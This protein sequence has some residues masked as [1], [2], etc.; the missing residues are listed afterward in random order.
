MVLK[1]SEK[2]HFMQ[3][4]ADF[5]K[6]SKSIKVISIYASERS[7]YTFSENGIVYYDLLLR[8]Y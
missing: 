3:F 2:V 7:H 5:S 1:L 8:R 6:K 4:S